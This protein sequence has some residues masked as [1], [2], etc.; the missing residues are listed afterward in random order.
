MLVAME[1]NDFS[2]MILGLPPRGLRLPDSPV[3]P[4]AVLETLRSLASSIAA[5]FTPAAWM[6]VEDGE[7][8]GICSVVKPYVEGG[9]EIGYGVAPTRQR[10]GVTSRALAELLTWARNDERVHEV[11]AECNMDNTASQ[12]VLARNGFVKTGQRVDEQDGNLIC[13]SAKTLR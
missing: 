13:W 2:E 9:I 4:V 12:I 10:K 1:D 11:I 8:A 7:V 5:D 3:A 6:F